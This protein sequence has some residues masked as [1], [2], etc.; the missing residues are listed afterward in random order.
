MLTNFFILEM[1]LLSFIRFILHEY[2]GTDEVKPSLNISNI[3][4]LVQ[5]HFHKICTLKPEQGAI[6]NTI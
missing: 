4:G 3:K 6:L 1:H 2:R 5:K